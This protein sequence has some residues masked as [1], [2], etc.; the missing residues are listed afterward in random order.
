MRHILI[1]F[2]FLSVCFQTLA[3]QAFYQSQDIE[4][5]KNGFNLVNPWAGGANVPQLSVIDLNKDG[6]LDLII[7]DKNGD[8]INCFINKG[9]QGEVDYHYA[10]EY[11]LLFPDLE[12]WVLLRDYDCDGQIDV[13][14]S[15]NGAIRVYKNSNAS[16]E[17]NFSLIGT[18]LTDRGTGPTNLYVSSVDIPHIG[19]LDFDGD[20]D[21]L[22]FSI[23]GSHVE[24]HKNNSIEKF[25][26]CDSL[27]FTLEDDCWGDFSENFSDNSVTLNDCAKKTE[28]NPKEAKHSGSTVTALDL[29]NDSY[30]ELL[31]GDV[32]FDNLVMLENSASTENAFMVSQDVN[33]PDYNT[34]ISLTKF[35]AAYYLD[36]NN[37]QQKDLII[38]PNGNNVSHNYEN[39]W[40]YEN[41]SST[42][43]VH[44]NLVQKNVLLDEMIEVGSGAHPVFFDYNKDG[45]MDLIVANYGYYITGG[46]FN[47]QLALYEN[48]GTLTEPL[49]EWISD[50]YAG[51]GL[52]NF[53][54]NIIPTFGDIDNDGDQDMLLGDSNG[55]IHLMKN[56][57]INGE[58]NFFMNSVNYLDIDVGSFASP[59]FIDLDRDGDLDLI[60]GSRQ[61]QIFHYE[62]Q[63]DANEA[64]LVLANDTLGNINLTDPIYNTAYTT[65][66]IIDTDNGYE[67]FVGTEKGHL[68]HYNTIDDNLD[69]SFEL[70]TDSMQLY[71]K[72]IKTAPALFDL[73]NDGWSD[74]LIGLYTGGVHLLWGG[75]LNEFSTDELKSQA[76]TIY[77][78]PSKG[79]FNISSKKLVSSICVYSLNGTE[80][81]R[82]YHRSTFNLTEFPTGLYFVKVIFEDSTIQYSKVSLLK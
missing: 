41:T 34:S 19:D 64:N 7:F 54:N 28:T 60:I 47:S 36:L 46:N 81:L 44:L 77:P 45:L 62:N 52:L 43:E 70:V 11:N 31:L 12:D 58:A 49:F 82:T 65:P 63:G 79:T 35:P 51:L 25:G 30:F 32:T 76:L 68:Y 72:S 42:E 33:F 71:S 29:N 39:I 2:T 75:N 5:I 56:I 3:Q 74:L 59:F 61:G 67:L 6:I 17:L 73:N 16:E 4:I 21:I 1:V 40:F 20:L 53:D 18:I 23:I 66:T 80:I 27:D 37:D 69:G 26:S 55:K 50:D 48:V 78:N 15:N 8:Q 24:W 57:E 14:T 38:T 9:T 13:F 22:T 10:P